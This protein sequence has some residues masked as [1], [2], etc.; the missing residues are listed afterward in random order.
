MKPKAA[1]ILDNFLLAKWQEDALEEVKKKLDIE[2]I[3]NC[4][5]TKT[6]KNFLKTFFI[7]FLIFFH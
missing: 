4:K 6:K 1:I 5:N 2:L 7:I 3:L